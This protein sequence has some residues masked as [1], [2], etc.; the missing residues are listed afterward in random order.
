MKILEMFKSKKLSEWQMF[1]FKSVPDVDPQEVQKWINSFDEVERNFPLA[2]ALQVRDEIE[3]ALVKTPSPDA[4][5]L[6]ECRGAL[7]ALHRFAAIYSKLNA[8][9][10]I[11]P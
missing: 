9:P 3:E 4:L 8:G 11:N 7:K 6:A 1:D 10:E 2:L 5:F